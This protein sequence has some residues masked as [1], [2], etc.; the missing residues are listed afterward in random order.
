MRDVAYIAVVALGLL[1]GGCGAVERKPE[2]RSDAPSP[3]KAT[4]RP[5]EVTNRPV[6]EKP[7]TGKLLGKACAGMA[8]QIRGKLQPGATV[9]VLPFI[10]SDGGVRRLG[11][12]LAS[13]IEQEL[14]NKGAK[15]VDRDNIGKLL[16]EIDLRK[17]AS[18]QNTAL[19]R[20]EKFAKADVLVLGSMIYFSD[21]LLVSAKALRV[22]RGTSRIIAATKSISLPAK[23]L[24]RLMWYVRR[25]SGVEVTGELPPLAFRYEFISPGLSGNDLLRDGQT[26]TSGQKFRIHVQPNS[27]CYLYVL[28]VDGGNQT[29][30]LFPH[31]KIGVS[32]RVRGSATCRVPEG[33]TWYW[34]DDNKG[35]ET[36]YLV[37]SYTPLTGLETI[38]A[39]MRTSDQGRSRARETV[40]KEIDTIVSRGTSDKTAGSV[41]PDGHAI[42]TRGIGGTDDIGW[43]SGQGAAP[44]KDQGSGLVV[45]GYATVVQKITLKHQ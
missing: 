29:Q 8:E 17:W 28:H 13:Q 10:D 41:K 38:L 12:L 33:T 40:A 27:D 7:S 9:A 21:E 39:T 1:L 43:G 45:S 34:F 23:P 36:F 18:G 22:G 37:A 32:N 15:L 11:V 26:V 20:P 30:V 6:R 19:A 2:P 44:D 16:D 5:A 42:R 24:G 14:A 31:G 4:S 25:P 3:V 35:T